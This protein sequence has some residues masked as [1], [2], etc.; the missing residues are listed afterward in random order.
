MLHQ[1]SQRLSLNYRD[2]KFVL[3]IFSDQNPLGP[4]HTT[5]KNAKIFLEKKNFSE[6]RCLYIKLLKNS[7]QSW[8]LHTKWQKM[9]LF[10]IH[11]TIFF[12]TGMN[13]SSFIYGKH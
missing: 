8:Q 2:G 4:L 12:T 1:N 9:Q 10:S 7:L 5:N 13:F 6:N 11:A 3:E